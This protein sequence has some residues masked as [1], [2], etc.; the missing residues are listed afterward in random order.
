MGE[1]V[2]GIDFLGQNFLP[3][4]KK[5]IY[6]LKNRIVF[7]LGQTAKMDENCVYLEKCIFPRHFI[8]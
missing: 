2:I 5:K 1:I 4:K 8:T 7:I 3:V 6:F